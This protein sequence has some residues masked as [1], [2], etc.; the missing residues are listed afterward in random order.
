MLCCI[1]SALLALP[2]VG[3]VCIC[4]DCQC[5][6]GGA[7]I[8]MCKDDCAE[9]SLQNLHLCPHDSRRVIPSPQG[10]KWFH[11]RVCYFPPPSIAITYLYSMKSVVF[12]VFLSVKNHHRHKNR[13]PNDCVLLCYVHSF[14]P[15]LSLSLFHWVTLAHIHPK[16]WHLLFGGLSSTDKQ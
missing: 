16:K 12:I 14:I 7:K 10:S 5:R 11:L 6:N 8:A 15:S 2:N 3:S 13:V 4:R 9:N 1:A